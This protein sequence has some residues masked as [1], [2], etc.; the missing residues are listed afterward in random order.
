MNGSHCDFM[1][2]EYAWCKW[3]S[4]IS[5]C[6]CSFICTMYIANLVCEVFIC[7]QLL[8]EAIVHECI[9]RLLK[10]SSDEESLECFAKL[11]TTIGKELD[12]GKG[13]VSMTGCLCTLLQYVFCEH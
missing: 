10:S 1:Y 3:R 11:M 4:Y 6:I 12:H 13:Q 9:Q 5:T 8:S 7:P 2:E